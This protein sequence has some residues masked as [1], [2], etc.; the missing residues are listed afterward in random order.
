MLTTTASDDSSYQVTLTGQISAYSALTAI[1]TFT[2]VIFDPTFSY[3]STVPVSPI[4]YYIGDPAL[5]TTFTPFSSSRTYLTPLYTV[6]KSDWSAINPAIM[7]FSNL[8]FNV[9]STSSADA[10]TY[11]LL[12]VSYFSISTPYNVSSAFTVTIVD[13]CMR[14]VITAP[15]VPDYSY[16]VGS[17]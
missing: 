5:T 16:Q 13:A 7:G 3:I 17:P 2:I 12:L 10:G 11:S 6:V 9:S 4:T 14:N 1:V 8:A 15:T